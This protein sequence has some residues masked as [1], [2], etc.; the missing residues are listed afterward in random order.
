MKYD[1]PN[2]RIYVRQSWL[3]DVMICPERSRLSLTLP[4]FRMGSDATII[5]TA[6]HYAIEQYLHDNYGDYGDDMVKIVEA[7]QHDARHKYNE[8]LSLPHR[9]TGLDNVENCIDAMVSAWFDD[10]RPHVTTGGQIEARFDV[11]LGFVLDGYEVCVS[12]TMDYVA[13]DG[14]L[15]DWKTASRTYNARDKQSSAIQATV[16]AYAAG[17]LG[18]VPEP[19]AVDFKYGIMIRQATPKAQIVHV[20]RTKEHIAWLRNQ[21]QS[22]VTMAH[23]LGTELAW[24]R[25]DQGNLCSEKWCDFWSVCKGACVSSSSMSLPVG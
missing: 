19:H 8:L 3:N 13:P 7:M 10:I 24:I 16:Y 9:N 20:H 2:K 22:V 18:W 25:N 4:E 15:W 12:G 14:M 11:P 1:I 21:V 6:V 23:N 17:A 5:G